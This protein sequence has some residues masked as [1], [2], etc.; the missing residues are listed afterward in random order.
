M[1]SSRVFSFTDPYQYQ[2]AIR[3]SSERISVTA[4]GD[5]RASLTQIDL[6]R[7]WMQR[8][9][10]NLPEVAVSATCAERVALHFLADHEQAPYRSN[11]MELSPGEITIDAPGAESTH[12]THGPF[13]WASLSLTLKDFAAAG[14][15][16]D[17]E[18]TIPTT[19]RRVRPPPAS[20]TRLLSL[21]RRA[22]DFSWTAPDKL[23]RR[24]VARSLEQ[25]LIHALVRCLTDDSSDQTT[26]GDRQRAAVI[27]RFENFLAANYAR[28]LYTMEICEA[29]RTSERTLQVCCNEQLGMSPQHYLWLRRMH[30]A[31]QALL[32]ADPATTTVT[33]VST[34]HGFW[35][36]GRFSVQYAGLFGESPSA[37]LR[38]PPV[39]PRAVQNRPFDLPITEFA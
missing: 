26:A 30:L 25:A 37:T 28:P 11:G 3:A 4:K 5:F 34:D 18:L 20:M 16:A 35:E 1:P 38:R 31:R 14:L 2:H 8:A 23:T 27:A 24:G 6:D 13:R 33:T 21:H 9:S 15:L 17:R 39:E 22:V 32:R 10:V 36:L 7:V 19:S 12:G 29:T